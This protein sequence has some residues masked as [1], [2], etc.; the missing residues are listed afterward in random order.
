MHPHKKII[1][2]RKKQHLASIF[3]RD[4]SLMI[5]RINRNALLR[6]WTKAN[7]NVPLLSD[8]KEQFIFINQ[9]V[10]KNGDIDYLEFGVYKG[11]S[12]STWVNIN[13]SIR[14]RFFGFD[15]FDG[16]PTQWF[17]DAP[18]G[19]FGTGG[20][21]PIINDTRVKFIKGIFQ[22]TLR[23]FL[24][25]FERKNRLVIH[26]DSDLYSSAF[27]VLMNLHPLFKNGDIVIFD[28][29]IDPIGEFLLFEEYCSSFFVTPKV[30]SMVVWKGLADK[31]AFMF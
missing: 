18:K 31:V 16:L 8:R 2:I 24:E 7:L 23:P 15:S 10:L 21:I 19:T 4:Y 5:D 12:I 26:I 20:E 13:N 1:N 6:K 30:L 14:S 22:E 17:P 9:Q 3:W 11:D 28:D 27:F 29:F 25:T